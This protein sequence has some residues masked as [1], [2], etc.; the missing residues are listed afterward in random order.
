MPLPRSQPLY[1][2]EDRFVELFQD[3]FGPA[4]A[5]MLVEQYHYNDLDGGERFIDFALESVLDRY[6]IEIDGETFHHPAVLDSASYADQLFR[7]NSLTHEGWRVLRWS[8]W[9]LQKE[10]E[11]V[12]EH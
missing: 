6:A 7:Q 10:P 3:V 2:T 5:G 8:D 12:K 4:A 1:R 9:Q 11:R